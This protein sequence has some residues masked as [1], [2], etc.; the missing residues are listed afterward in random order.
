M[1]W[2]SVIAITQ[3]LRADLIFAT[4]LFVMPIIASKARFA[5]SPP[6][7]RASINTSGVICQETPHLVLTPATSAFLPAIADDY[8]PVAVG[9]FLIIG[10]DLKRECFAL[11][12]R[13]TA[14]DTNA[15]NTV[16]RWKNPGNYLADKSTVQ[17]TR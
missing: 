6:A 13:R 9:L 1:T 10:R 7:A 16:Q 12:E 2:S 14:I 3:P 17:L 8:F 11:L 4:S 15:A 5:S